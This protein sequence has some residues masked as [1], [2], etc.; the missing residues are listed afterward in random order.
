MQRRIE[1]EGATVRVVGAVWD[2]AHEA[3]LAFARDTQALYVS[4]F[5]HPRIWEGHST[6]VDEVVEEA[7]LPEAVVVSVGG[8]GLLCGVVE[9]L[10]RHGGDAVPVV[11]VETEGTAS[12]AAALRE[13]R[14]ATLEQ[15]TGVA[16][17]LGARTVCRKA[18]EWGACH[19]V[20]SV[21]VPDDRAIRACLGFADDHRFLVEPACGASLAV[22]YQTHPSLADA[23]RVVV[24]VC[25]GIAANLETLQEWRC[26]LAD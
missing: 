15:I 5:D 17:S 21:V 3:A 25:G 8:G 23:H 7:G 11:A 12:L 20:R 6:L 4:P 19:P 26:L 14:L 1:E 24:V 10:R 13:G 16:T 2:E 18:L 22:A 9:G